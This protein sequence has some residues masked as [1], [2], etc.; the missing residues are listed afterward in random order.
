MGRHW[1]CDKNLYK[2]YLAAS[3]IRYSG[4]ALSEVSP[5]ELWHDAVSRWLKSERYTASLVW[6][7]SKNLIDKSQPCLLIGDDTVLSKQKYGGSI[8]P[9]FR[10]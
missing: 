7:E 9:I 10:K 1:I 2:G 5:R 6:E 4:V 8:F 3:S